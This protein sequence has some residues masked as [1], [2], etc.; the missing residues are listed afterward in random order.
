[1]RKVSKKLIKDLLNTITLIEFN[2]N[3]LLPEHSIV[4]AN[5]VLTNYAKYFI[6]IEDYRYVSLKFWN[7]VYLEDFYQAISYFHNV[8]PNWGY[9][10][11]KCYLTYD[12]FI[13]PDFNSPSVSEDFQQKFDPNID[14]DSL[15]DVAIKPVNV[16]VAYALYLSMVLAIEIILKKELKNYEK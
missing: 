3:S 10:L 4:Y 11:G 13:F 7:D 15:T 6:D 12:A 5:N 8:F 14:W 9:K 2:N 1:M 16:T